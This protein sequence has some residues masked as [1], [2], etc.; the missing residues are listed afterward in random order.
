MT[1]PRRSI[2]VVW[3]DPAGQIKR[4]ELVGSTNDGDTDEAVRAAMASFSGF[5]QGPPQGMPQPVRLR[6]V[7]GA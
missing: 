1:P 3:V 6:I 4:F 7:T 5:G 2:T